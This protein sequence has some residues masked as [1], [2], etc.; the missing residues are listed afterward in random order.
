MNGTMTNQEHLGPELRAE[1]TEYGSADLTEEST[2][3]EPFGLFDAWMADAFAARDAGNL[4]EPTAMQVATVS[5]DGHPSVRTVLLKGVQDG[6]FV[7]F[8]NY[9]S[10]K[11]NQI[12]SHD[13][14]AL[15]FWWPSLQRQVRIEGMVSKV[16]RGASEE[17]FATRPRASQIGAWASPQSRIVRGR[18][19]LADDY[20]AM[21]KKFDGQDVPCPPHWG[22]Y[23]VRPLRIEFW[24]GQPSRMHDRISFRKVGALW[25]KVRLAP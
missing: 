6:R 18:D 12:A 3:E 10:D 15:H 23:Q 4:L 20:A 24:Q 8:T 5:E 7:F 14:A 2:P 19:Q 17:Y 11:G 13:R 21:E 9:D 25:E 22:G 16:T 1:R